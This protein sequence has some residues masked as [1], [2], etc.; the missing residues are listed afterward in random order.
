MNSRDGFGEKPSAGMR[1][2]PVKKTRISSSETS[3]STVKNRIG[4]TRLNTVIIT[5][6]AEL[7]VVGHSITKVMKK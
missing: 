4:A 7:K 1:S 2:H 5:F 6:A 3:F